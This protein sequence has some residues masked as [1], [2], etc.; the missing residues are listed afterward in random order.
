[1]PQLLTRLMTSEEAPGWRKFTVSWT[2]IEKLVQ[3]ISRR[4][5]D[6]SMLVTSPAWEIAPSPLVIT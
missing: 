1:M 2:A 3:S 4:A 5:L 6:W